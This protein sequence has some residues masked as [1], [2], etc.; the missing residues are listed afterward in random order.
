MTS[1]FPMVA[2]AA[3]LAAVFANRVVIPNAATTLSSVARQVSR[4][5]RRNPVS[6]E[7]AFRSTVPHAGA[8]RPELRLRAHQDRPSGLPSV[9][10]SRLTGWPR[11]AR[12]AGRRCAGRPQTHG[13]DR[14]RPA[15][16][17]LVV[18]QEHRSAHAGRPARTERARRRVP[19]ASQPLCAVVLRPAAA[20]CIR[21]LKRPEIGIRPISAIRP[22]RLAMSC[23]RARTGC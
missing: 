20:T 16:V 8:T 13:C 10:C 7:L 6:R 19:Y 4:D 15:G 9:C 12:A 22:A 23:G 14:Q 17:D 18:D 2:P 1:C 21:V 3:L 11:R 5:N